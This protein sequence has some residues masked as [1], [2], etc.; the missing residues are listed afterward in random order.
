MEPVISVG[1]FVL[2]LKQKSYKKQEI[3]A[4]STS[5]NPEYIWVHRIIEKQKDCYFTKGDNAQFIDNY[6]ICNENIL[7]KVIFYTDF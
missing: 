1:D 7:G 2:I 3:V 4:Y 6:K 5:S